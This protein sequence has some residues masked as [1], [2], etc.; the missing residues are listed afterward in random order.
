MAEIADAIIDGELC[1]GCQCALPGPAPGGPRRCS[2]CQSDPQP[3]TIL[4]VPRKPGRAERARKAARSDP[5]PK[6][7]LEASAP[8]SVRFH[9]NGCARHFGQPGALVDHLRDAHAVAL[10]LPL[11]YTL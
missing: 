6:W 8:F 2:G 4:Q 5:L 9:C 1:E 3:G 10:T 11:E 7:K